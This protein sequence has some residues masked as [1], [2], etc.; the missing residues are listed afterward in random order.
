MEAPRG[1]RWFSLEQSLNRLALPATSPSSQNHP[2]RS[3]VLGLLAVVTVVALLA[4]G[5]SSSHHR[6]ANPSTSSSIAQ[7]TT[8]TE[9]PPTYSA[10]P[11]SWDRADSAAL[12]V[13]GGQS[14]TLSAALAPQLTGPWMVF[15][16]RLGPSGTPTATVWSSP[17]A[18]T[19]T[20]GAIDSTGE[21]S[22]AEAAARYRNT[23]V[24]VGSTDAG[25][26]EQ[27]AVWTS[28]G[29][30][31]PFTLQSVP[32]SNGPSVMTLVA[33][34]A[35]GMF[36][37]GTVD[38][39]FAMWSSTNGRQWSELPS[40][41]KVIGSS[42]DSRVNALIAEGDNIYAAGSVQPGADQQAALWTTSD[43]LNW[44]L[45]GSATSSFAGPEAT[46]IYSLAPLGSGLVAVG[47]V[48]Q[49][50]GWVP[51][52]WISPDGQ[53]WSLAS[54]DFPAVPHPGGAATSLGPSGG[55]SARSVAAIPTLAG[56]NTVVA[57]GGGSYGQDAWESADGIH[58]TSLSMP[59]ND[60]SA[61][62]WRAEVTAASADR[63]VV[64]D[65]EAGQ[66]YLLTD[67]ASLATGQGG[68]FAPAAVPGSWSQ[69]S[70]N[71]AVFGPVRAD[72]VPVATAHLASGGLQLTVDLVHRPQGIGGASVA[73]MVLESAD[74]ATWAAAPGAQGN[75]A[76]PATLPA[77][78]ALTARLPA[79]WV[80]VAST[81]GGPAATWTSPTGAAWTRTAQLSPTALPTGA[82][83]TTSS[84]GTT[85]AAGTGV[86]PAVTVNGVCTVRLPASSSST[87]PGASS[88][89]A[90]PTSAAATRYL[91]ASVGAVSSQASTP[92]SSPG[93]PATTI[94]TRAAGAWST[95]TGI[96]WRT[97]SVGPAPPAGATAS[98][99]GC[100][101][102]GSTLAG[103]GTAPASNGAPQPAVWRSG[104]GVTWTRTPVSAFG[105]G[106]PTPLV[107]LATE[108]GDWLAA[109]NPDPTAD[110]LQPGVA[111]ARGPAATAGDDGGV[112]PAPSVEDG[113]EA[114]WLSADGGTAWQLLDTAAAPWLGNQRSSIDL[115]AFVGATPV[116]VGAAD[117]Q[118]VVWIGTAVPQA[119]SGG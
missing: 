59:V 110:P 47:A 23:T 6:R 49:A 118:L 99:S 3:R 92:S 17:D 7:T 93:T 50:S 39:R 87:P 88:S 109:A 81:A 25:A 45:V 97:A 52:S 61:T 16:S 34:G 28:T 103:F 12:Q 67:Q 1:R 18:L 51:A 15:G 57:T 32:A 84:T 58:W 95:P 74:G 55:T 46:A 13:G 107:S 37:A 56:T 76:K 71:P 62:S 83:S 30:G 73:T 35:L 10:S 70:A 79:G 94:V 91:A 4:A 43:G 2:R 36:A 82:G 113:R 66:P 100:A 38:G 115:V 86:G 64:L 116:V 72:A 9:P 68:G 89:S 44:R 108:G 80:A 75:T 102:A 11:F 48:D 112:G 101:A 78:S 53:S 5:C 31:V 98:M 63:A 42:P 105:S 114:L 90:V 65:A 21:P 33:A 106:T 20:A 26:G 77:T 119:S 96:S 19:W 24:V 104:D 40:A 60:A 29:A 85:G 22:Q 14:A 111:G 8:T 41:E 27:A 69:P 117:G 54:V